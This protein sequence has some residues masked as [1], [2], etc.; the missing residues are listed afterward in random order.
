MPTNSGQFTQV[1]IANAAGAMIDV[2]Q[3]LQGSVDPKISSADT[4]LPTFQAGGAPSAANHI[5]GATQS[6]FPLNFFYDPAL[7]KILRQIVC[8][9]S[10]FLVQIKMG[11]NNLP[12]Q[13]DALFT[14]T[15]TCVDFDLVSDTNKPMTIVFNLCP[16][17]GGAVNPTFSNI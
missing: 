4:N 5:R 10:G 14:G 16:A 17:D 6:E 12:G 1:L 9:R 7:A 11:A 8:A 15:Y 3:Y 13:G 2:S